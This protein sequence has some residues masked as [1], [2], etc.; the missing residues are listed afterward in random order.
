MEGHG[1]ALGTGGINMDLHFY[2][3]IDLLYT[4][5]Y[6]HTHNIYTYIFKNL[7]KFN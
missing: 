7:F 1:V 4:H 5:R 6:R 2:M 3:D